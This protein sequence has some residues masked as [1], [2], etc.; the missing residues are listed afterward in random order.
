[1]SAPILE[2]YVALLWALPNLHNFVHWIG[3]AHPVSNC[4]S[5]K[6]SF[7]VSKLEMRCISNKKSNHSEES[8]YVT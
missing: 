4:K 5:H 1:M 2:R 7:Q 8:L 3:L 6:L